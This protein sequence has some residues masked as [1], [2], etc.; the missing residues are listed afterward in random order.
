MD[1]LLCC[2]NFSKEH[3]KYEATKAGGSVAL[4]RTA[5]DVEFYKKMAQICLAFGVGIV[6][7]LNTMKKK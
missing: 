5:D 1:E 2:C 6:V 7:G 3:E 4:Q